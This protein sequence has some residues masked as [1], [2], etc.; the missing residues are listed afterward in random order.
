MLIFIFI[1]NNLYYQKEMICNLGLEFVRFDFQ[2][3]KE[4]YNK[5]IKINLTPVY[6]EKGKSGIERYDIG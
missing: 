4:K 1:F 6:V 5:K 3:F 2:K